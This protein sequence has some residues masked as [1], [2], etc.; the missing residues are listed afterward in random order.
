[1]K[2]VVTR[3]HLQIAVL[4]LGAILI[5]YAILKF[6]F[7]LNFGD[8]VEQN[9]PTGVIIGAV[10]IFGWNRHLLAQEKK[11]LEAEDAKQKEAEATDGS[12]IDAA[13]PIEAPKEVDPKA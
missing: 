7:K 9:L 2:I 12:A 13:L 4:A 6:A 1:M 8:F 11:A 3:K 5:L 10:A